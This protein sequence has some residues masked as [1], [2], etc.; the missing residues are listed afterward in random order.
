MGEKLQLK[1]EWH[2]YCTDVDLEDLSWRRRSPSL[3]ASHITT[4]RRRFSEFCVRNIDWVQ[5][6]NNGGGTE[7]GKFLECVED[8]L[9]TQHVHCLTTDQSTLDLVFTREPELVS[10]VQDL[11]PFASSDHHLL[12]WAI[13]RS[14]DVDRDS[15]KVYDYSKMDTVGIRN[16]M[17]KVDWQLLNHGSVD[18]AWSVFKGILYDLRDRFVPLK[19]LGKYCR[20][21]PVWMSYKA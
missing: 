13:N 7:E 5:C 19:V 3:P 6:C 12:T 11:G 20:K 17:A 18:E 4:K 21:K 2:K 15:K 9:L 1:G 10:D 8:C 16:E 14:Y